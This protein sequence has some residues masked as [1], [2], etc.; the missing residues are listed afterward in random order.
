MEDILAERLKRILQT[1]PENA[2]EEVD[3]TSFLD[4]SNLMTSRQGA[5]LTMIAEAKRRDW[6]EDELVSYFNGITGK[7]IASWATID[8]VG[9]CLEDTRPSR[10]PKLMETQWRLQHEIY[11]SEQGKVS[12]PKLLLKLTFGNGSSK[13]ISCSETELGQL[14]LQLR[15]LCNNLKR[16]SVSI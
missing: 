4:N 5:L 7:E 16:H 15:D 2:S 8:D 6:S 12:R 14:S 11:N 1:A 13:V 3:T 9:Q 10:A